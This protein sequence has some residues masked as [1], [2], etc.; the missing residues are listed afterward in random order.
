MWYT[1]LGIKCASNPWINNEL[2]IHIPWDQILGLIMNL[3]YKF[4]GIKCG[5]NPWTNMCIESSSFLC[6]QYYLKTG[7]CKFG[8][9]CKFHHPR[10]KGQTQL[11]VF[12]LP[13]RPVCGL[14]DRHA[15]KGPIWCILHIHFYTHSYLFMY[16]QKV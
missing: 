6:P 1:F 4:L 7:T 9:T 12:N 8:T 14:I 5:S 16:C 10:D 2:V 15:Y 3:S 11:N 13:L